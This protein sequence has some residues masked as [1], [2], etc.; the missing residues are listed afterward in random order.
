MLKTQKNTAGRIFSFPKFSIQLSVLMIAL[1]FLYP[2]VKQIWLHI[3]PG[4]GQKTPG[5]GLGHIEARLAA[6]TS[7]QQ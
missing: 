7:C 5:L 2:G 4:L 3:C 6:K 1:W